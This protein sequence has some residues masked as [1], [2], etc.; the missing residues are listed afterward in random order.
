MERERDQ[1]NR[2]LV[3]L[4]MCELLPVGGLEMAQQL[5]QVVDIVLSVMADE[6]QTTEEQ[7]DYFR[8]LLLS[9]LIDL[10]AT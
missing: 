7:Y 8:P 10:V 4:S 5:P 2:K 6:A 9:S 1:L 3:G